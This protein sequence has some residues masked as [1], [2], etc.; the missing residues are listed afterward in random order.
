LLRADRP[1]AD[2][3]DMRS[4]RLL[5]ILAAVAAVALPVAGADAA[6]RLSLRVADKAAQKSAANVVAG[7]EDPDGGASI[8][9]FD[10]SPCDRDTRRRADCDV[11][12]VFDD[13]TECDDTIHVRLG[14]RNRVRVTAD[15]DDSGDHVFEDCTDPEDDATGDDPGV[16]DAGDD[17][18]P[19]DDPAADGV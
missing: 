17:V 3:G 7:Y 15:S 5:L 14:A 9:S 16:D 18:T 2:N 13:G 19:V 1:A 6:S 10:L 4:T 8:E 11:T 12:Y